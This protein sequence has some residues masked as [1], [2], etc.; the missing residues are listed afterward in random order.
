MRDRKKH[1]ATA[2]RVAS[3]HSAVLSQGGGYPSPSWGEV[4]Q[5]CPD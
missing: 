4:P 5:S 3:T 2:R 1:T